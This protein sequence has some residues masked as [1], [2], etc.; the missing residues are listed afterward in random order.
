MK[1]TKT[2]STYT[3]TNVPVVAALSHRHTMVAQLPDFEA[4]SISLT[5]FTTTTEIL[6]GDDIIVDTDGVEDK[7][8]VLAATDNGD[9]TFTGTFA[10]TERTETPTRVLGGVTSDSVPILLVQGSDTE[11]RIMPFAQ[12][13]TF[14]SATL[15]EYVGSGEI[16]NI[17]R[18]GDTISISDGV[19]PEDAVI[20]TVV[21]S[22]TAPAIT[23]TI[24]YE[25]AATIT[26]TEDVV[27]EGRASAVDTNVVSREEG[28][29]DVTIEY[30]TSY[31][32]T[33]VDWNF[34]SRT[35]Q[36]KAGW[37]IAEPFTMY[38]TENIVP[39]P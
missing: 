2:L 32:L 3:E 38:Y 14:V 30:V 25:I 10:D 31:N 39:T 16:T 18:V 29:I 1:A 11:D 24:T 37:V 22:G 9:G 15:T 27:V 34:I 19:T 26:A 6:T 33:D 8:T 36:A 4:T 12:T 17:V 5:A 35:I 21:E 23:Y 7:D 20:L 13:L 28:S